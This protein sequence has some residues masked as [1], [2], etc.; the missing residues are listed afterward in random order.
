VG[1]N[2]KF[3]S[4]KGIKKA[5]VQLLGDKPRKIVFTH[6]APEGVEY[7]GRNHALVEG[8]ARYLFEEALVVSQA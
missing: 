4:V 2:C 7:V 6:P 1:N 8:L 3:C 5:E